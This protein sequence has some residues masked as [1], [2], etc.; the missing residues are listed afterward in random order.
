MVISFK[1]INYLTQS[2]PLLSP[3]LL[4]RHVLCSKGKSGKNKK[5]PRNQVNNQSFFCSNYSLSLSVCLFPWLSVV[6][7]S[8]LSFNSQLVFSLDSLQG[9]VFLPFTL[10][11]PVVL[12]LLFL[13]WIP[14]SSIIL[15]CLMTWRRRTCTFY[16]LYFFFSIEQL[17]KKKNSIFHL[18]FSCFFR[19][20]VERITNS[21]R[22][23]RELKTKMEE[24]W[25]W[26]K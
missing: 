17:K 18:D 13:V 19:F 6:L 5:H 23:E 16:L 7:S 20:S 14:F 25:H 11:L 26:R 8:V 15:S 21:I 4:D 22:E 24:K 3:S 2:S 1:D 10:P 9:L 12:F